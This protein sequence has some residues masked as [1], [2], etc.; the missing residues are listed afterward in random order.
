MRTILDILRFPLNKMGLAHIGLFTLLVFVMMF[1]EIVLGKLMGRF[2]G[3]LHLV[4][5]F[6]NMLVAI[7]IIQ[8]GYLCTQQSAQGELFAPDKM[9]SDAFQIGSWGELFEELYFRIS[10][11]VVCF[12]PPILYL[13]LTDHPDTVFVVLLAAG[14]FY[15]PMLFLAVAMFNSS[16]SFNPLIHFVSIV[17]TFFSYCL[18]VGQFCILVVL[19]AL[20]VWLLQKYW[21]MSMVLFPLQLYY[22]MVIAHLFGRYYCLNE[23]K[24]KWEV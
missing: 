12:G 17:K 5:M 8:Y 15:F 7:E 4:L 16:T 18:L 10:P 20:F 9:F 24:L 22:M 3:Y 13:V 19:F 23:Q 14:V 21:L 2:I 1:V 11:F 6:I